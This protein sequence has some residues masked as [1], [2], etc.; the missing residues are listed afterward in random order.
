MAER[1]DWFCVASEGRLEST[2]GRPTTANVNAQANIILTMREAQKRKVGFRGGELPVTWSS[3]AKLNHQSS[4][5]GVIKGLISSLAELDDSCPDRWEG[6]VPQPWLTV[7]RDAVGQEPWAEEGW[8]TS[9]APQV[10]LGHRAWDESLWERDCP[11]P[12]LVR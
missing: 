7:L 12:G 9:K 3:Q 8:P 4:V 5:K 2:G 6:D 1:A 11:G 10:V